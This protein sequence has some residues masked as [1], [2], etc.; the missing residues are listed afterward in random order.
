MTY[1]EGCYIAQGRGR[2]GPPIANI[3]SV[4]AIIMG[5]VMQK[6]SYYTRTLPEMPEHSFIGHFT[7]LRVKIRLK[8]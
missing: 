3:Y 6:R 4:Y 2:C 8:F 7:H 5:L 1:R